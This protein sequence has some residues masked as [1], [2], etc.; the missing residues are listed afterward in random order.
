VTTLLAGCKLP[1]IAGVR[2]NQGESKVSIWRQ[3]LKEMRTQVNRALEE[4][5]TEL[6]AAVDNTRFQVSRHL[7]TDTFGLCVFFVFLL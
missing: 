2:P 1:K 7:H 6:G 5:R 3:Q 4:K